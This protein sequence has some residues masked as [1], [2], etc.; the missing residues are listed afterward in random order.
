MVAAWAAPA[1]DAPAMTRTEPISSG[2]RDRRTRGT[3]RDRSSAHATDRPASSASVPVILA[4]TFGH[5][6]CSGSQPAVHY[7]PTTATRAGHRP[8]LAAAKGLPYSWPIPRGR[9]L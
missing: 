3:A 5:R 7:A 4:H 8:V 6:R 9:T 2:W 1:H